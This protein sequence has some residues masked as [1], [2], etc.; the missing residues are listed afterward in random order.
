VR[1]L[2]FV[3]VCIL[4]LIYFLIDRASVK[5]TGH[6]LLTSITARV[7]F[8]FFVW[9]E[10]FSALGFAQGKS[11]PRVIAVS[12]ITGVVMAAFYKWQW[13]RKKS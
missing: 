2:P 9:F 8:A 13:N 4:G 5:R 3:T 6:L 1:W 10:A 11:M 12:A 7:V